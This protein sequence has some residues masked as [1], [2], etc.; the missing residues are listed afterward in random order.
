M[1]FSLKHPGIDIGET[2]LE[3]IFINTYMTTAGEIPLKVYILGLSMARNG[4]A[5]QNNYDIASILNI[6][7]SQVKEA[8]LYWKERKIVDFKL[9]ESED[10]FRFDIQFLSLRE[11]YINSNFVQKTNAKEVETTKILYD[12]DIKEL[13]EEL[14][15]IVRSPLSP[16]AR[17]RMIDW[18][19]EF[20]VGRDM[21]LRAIKITY[22]ENPPEKPS[23]NYAKGILAKWSKNGIRTVKEAAD[24]EAKF[25]KQSEFYREVNY[26]LL[27]KTSLP[28]EAQMQIIENL[29][30][31]LQDKSVFFEIVDLCSTDY[32]YPTFNRLQ[33][34]F[35]KLE[36]EYALTREGIAAYRAAKQNETSRPRSASAGADKSKQNFQ[37]NTYANLSKEEAI[38]IMQK[39]N[40]ALLYD[41]NKEK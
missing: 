20:K 32:V 25:I 17:L 16:D 10:D 39:K 22:L 38:K 18:L 12:P 26:R 21:L 5:M 29:L 27:S 15:Q 33:N 1:G 41:P 14:E 6:D 35:A 2:P 8:W 4:D 24:Y 9:P 37:Q 7:I 28:T 23:L 36:K 3:N 11:R 19:R 40:P 31:S 34:L 30:A 13:F